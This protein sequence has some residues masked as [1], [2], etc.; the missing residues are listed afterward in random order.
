MNI[1]FDAFVLETNK[2]CMICI[3]RYFFY[4]NN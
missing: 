1:I 4:I 2:L 3:S